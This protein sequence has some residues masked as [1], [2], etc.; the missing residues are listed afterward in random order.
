[1]IE[2]FANG[3]VRSWASILD[4][5]TREQAVRTAELEIVSAPIALM[6]D[7]HLGAGA[8]IGT[9]LVTENA[10][11]PMA[12]G[13][14][15]GCGM[16]ARKLAL[17]LDGLDDLAAGRWVS[18]CAATVPAGLGRWHE[19]ASEGA[20]RWLER[21]PPPVEL[22]DRRRAAEQLGTLGSGNHFIELSVDE[23]GGVWLLLHSGSRGAGNKLAQRHAKAA[24]AMNGAHA[25]DR[26][27]AWLDAGTPEFD[28]YV[29]D[30]YWS[31]A[32]AVENRREL[33]GGAHAALESVV[34]RPV[35][36]ED[37]VNCH[38]NY[39][40]FEEVAELGRPM[41]VTRKGAISARKGDRGLIPGAMGQASFVVTG[42]GN[43]ASYESCAHGAG[44]VMSRT[45]ARKEV[46]PDDFVARME[47]V[48]WQEAEA[49][50]LLDE[51]PQSYKDVETV[52]RDQADLVSIDHR[53]RAIANYKGVESVRRRR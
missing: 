41:Y 39:A 24:V 26:D 44:R 22:K 42:L 52:M 13:V 16:A 17:E 33:L 3:K 1:M 7:A 50:A 47:G 9:V 14:D 51:A 23:E 49:T 43:P 15:I 45:R 25:P 28:A 10:V 2:T 18:T 36:V 48:A 37:E 35:G 19:G 8:T 30:L 31:Q 27:L 12:V 34:E 5:P 4:E 29:R 32:Y 11:I 46:S 21:N 38:H 53:L 20:L 40:M 6:P